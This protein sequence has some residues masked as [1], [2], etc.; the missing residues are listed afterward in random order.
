MMS[1]VDVASGSAPADGGHGLASALP[2]KA[3]GRA[4]V[5]SRD[6]LRAL[7]EPV[8]ETPTRSASR[9]S[10][11]EGEPGEASCE[12]DDGKSEADDQEENH[13]QDAAAEVAG[14]R[15][16]DDTHQAAPPPS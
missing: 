9:G 1:L 13:A 2:A 3:R 11:D 12:E 6:P 4:A 16:T 5:G 14:Q 15:E 8:Y 10:D 7:P